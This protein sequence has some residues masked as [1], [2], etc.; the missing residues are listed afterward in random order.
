M[1]TLVKA[2]TLF[3]VILFSLGCRPEYP[4]CS[5]DEHCK[6]HE[7][8]VKGQCQQCK[9]DKHCPKGQECNKGRCTPIQGYCKTTDDCTD[10]R[11]C[12]NNRCIP[13]ANNSDCPDGRCKSG[14]CLKPGDCVTDEDCPENHEC[15]N[16]SCVAPPPPPSAGPCSPEPVYFDFNE[17]I[18]TSQAT[19]KLNAAAKCIRSVKDRTIRVEGHCDPRGTQAYNLALGDRRSR[20]V[21]HYLKRL[22]IPANR[23]RPM[24]KGNLEATGTDESSWAFDRKVV[25]FWE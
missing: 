9:K 8:C 25:F 3:G 24:S 4:K 18:L 21:L 23:V 20:S 15:Q 14:R 7:Y 13:C 16:G 17:F 11:F 19:A 1:H 12:K 2:A 22:G 6:E 10:G 5:K